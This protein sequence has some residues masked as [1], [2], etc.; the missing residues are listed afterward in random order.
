MPGL[1]PAL[2]EPRDPLAGQI[3]D[4]KID[5]GGSRQRE[6]DCGVAI[7]GIGKI[8]IQGEGVG[9]AFAAFLA[10]GCRRRRAGRD[11]RHQPHIVEVEGARHI[12]LETQD[13]D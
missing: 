9:P 2:D 13:V 4:R 5:R 12:A 11:L 10:N 6:A 3:V 7:E 1:T 8:L